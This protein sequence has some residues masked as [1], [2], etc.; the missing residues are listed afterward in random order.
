MLLGRDSLEFFVD[1]G[2]VL[3]AQIVSKLT[4]RRDHIGD[5]VAAVKAGVGGLV[6]RDIGEAGFVVFFGLQ[7]LVKLLDGAVQL[8]GADAGLDSQIVSSYLNEVGKLFHGRIFAGERAALDSG[9]TGC[10]SC[11]GAGD[12]HVDLVA[13]LH[14]QLDVGKSE[15]IGLDPFQ[16]CGKLIRNHDTGGI[17]D[18]D[19]VGTGPDGG[20]QCLIQKFGL[21]AG[22]VHSGKF[23][24]FAI[25]P[26][27]LYL[28]FNGLQKSRG[29]H[30]ALVFHLDRGNRTEDGQLGLLGRTYAFP[31]FFYISDGNIDGG[32]QSGGN[33]GRDGTVCK[34]ICLASGDRSKLNGI[35]LQTVKASGNFELFFEGK[36]LLTVLSA[37]P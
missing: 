31:G 33:H 5:G 19:L 16:E 2:V 27:L 1:D 26:C 6:K 15:N 13:D 37:L 32:R 17:A 22:G 18:G 24:M 23:Y 7:D 4:H 25:E 35:C 11:C 36:L 10:D 28:F 20:V 34:L 21:C 29:F 3:L 30:V 9:G 14:I 12:G 8:G